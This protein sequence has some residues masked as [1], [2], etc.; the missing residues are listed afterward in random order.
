MVP[1][2]NI[3]LTILYSIYEIFSVRFV[4][5]VHRQPTSV[6]TF[7]KKKEKERNKI[8][9]RKPEFSKEGSYILNF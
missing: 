6:F 4:C 1:R 8:Q 7:P 5:S 3:I 2:V 9:C